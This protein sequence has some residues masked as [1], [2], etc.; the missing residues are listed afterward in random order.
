M[1]KEIL[2]LS[3]GIILFLFGMMKLSMTVQQL[4]TLRIREYIK[5]AVKKPLY[6]LLTGITTTVLFQSSSATTFLTVGMVSA[7][8][9]TF[10]SLPGDHPGCRYRTTV[11]IFLVVWKFTDMSPLFLIVGVSSGFRE[12]Q[13]D[14]KPSGKPFFYFGLIF[15]GLSLASLATVPLKDHPAIIRFFQ[16]ARNPLLGLV[17]GILL[18]GLSMPPPSPSASW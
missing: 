8:L 13:N 9:I 17:I 7:G 1:I 5:Y 10:L 15:F 18:P 4:F 2:L 11:T 6:G 14:G 16:E 12:I 3:A